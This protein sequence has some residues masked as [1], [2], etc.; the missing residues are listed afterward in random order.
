MVEPERISDPVV[1]KTVGE[2]RESL[3]KPDFARLMYSF[4]QN[5]AAYV[6]LKCGLY[7]GVH[8]DQLSH[9]ESIDTEG[10]WSL[11]RKLS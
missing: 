10:K 3:T 5:A 6:K 1:P 11:C 8:M 7:V 9:M 4:D 2:A